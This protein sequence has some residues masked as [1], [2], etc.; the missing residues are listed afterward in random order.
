[1][2]EL[3]KDRTN[4]IIAGIV[5]LFT[6]IV[7]YLTVQPTLSYWDCGEFIACAYTLGIP[8]PPGSPLFII[9]GR[10]FSMIPFAE[11]ICYRINM[12]SV[13]SSATAV[14][15]G[16]LTVVRMI[17]LWFNK[18]T[19]GLKKY[20]VYIGGIAGSLLMAFATTYWANAVEA[21]VYGLSMTIMTVIL[22]LAIKYL[23]HQETAAGSKIIILA[24]FLAMSGVAVHLSTFLVLPVA[25]IFFIIRKG[26]PPKVWFAICGFLIAELMAILMFSSSGAGKEGFYFA[27]VLLLLGTV[28][29]V[30]KHIN[31]P[32][33]IGIGGFSMIMMGFYQFIYGVI[34]AFVVLLAFAIWAKHTDWKTGMAVLLVAVIGFSSHLFIPIRSAQSPRIDEN[35]AS[36]SFTTFVNYLERKQYGSQ[37]MVDRMFKRRGELSNQFGR[38]AHMGYWSYFEKQYGLSPIF[39]LLFILGILGIGYATWRKYEVGLPFIVMLLFASI[40]LVL[41]MNFA[42]GIKF[43]ASTGDA[44]LEVRNRDYFFTPAYAYF[45]LA[46]GL[47]IAALMDLV[48]RSVASEGTRKIAVAGVSVLAFLPAFALADNWHE[49]DR[50]GNYFPKIYSENILDTCE[51]NAILFTSGDNDT[52]PLWCVQEVYK[53]RTDV[54]VVNLSLFNTDWYIWQMKDKYNVPISLTEDQIVWN[55]YKVGNR[56]IRRPKAPYYDQARKKKRFLIPIFDPDEQRVLKLQDVMVDDVFLTNKGE[57]P[58]YFSSE[59]YVESP[60]KLRDKSISTGVLYKLDSTGYVRPINS[61]RGYDLYMDTYKFDGLNDPEIFRDENATGVM[62]GL[63]FNAVR[64]SDDLIRSGDTARAISILHFSINRYPEFLRSYLTLGKYYQ[65]TGDS[66][67]ADSVLKSFEPVILDLIDRDSESQFY[68]T[69]YGMYLY[70]QGRTE[71]ALKYLNDAFEINKNSGYAFQNLAQ[72]LY[73]LQRVNE[74]KNVTYAHAAYKMNLNNGMLQQLLAAFGRTQPGNFPAPNRPQTAPPPIPGGQ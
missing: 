9:I 11:D 47:G 58:I 44:Y 33:L 5:F 23:D 26:A 53:Y 30:Y 54:R 46:M 18:G 37:S 35:N 1:M 7:Y 3:V 27:T 49:N 36:R 16:Y 71:E 15:F 22:W 57:N 74:L 51:E 14:M 69:D 19:D 12:L 34:G 43:D 10:F 62:L 13:I 21:E 67:T 52:F 32:V 4:S 70:D 45:G 28:F 24:C 8:H 2:P 56:S 31:W 63:G 39:G 6:F 60:L 55:E 59:P 64:I 65:Y 61:E 72:T 38:H 50:S 42:D 73:D 25:A 66:A 29:V 68:L 48:R 40:G 41:Y 17:N 20:I